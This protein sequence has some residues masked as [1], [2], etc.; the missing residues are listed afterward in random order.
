VIRCWYRQSSGTEYELRPQDISGF[1]LNIPYVNNRG[2][3]HNLG[4]QYALQYTVTNAQQRETIEQIR[5]RAPQVNQTYGRMVNGEDYNVYPLNTNRAIKLKAVNR[6]YAGHNRYFDLNDP[7][8]KYQNTNVFAEDGIIYREFEYKYD[9]EPLPTSKDASEIIYDRI[10]P[11][12]QAPELANFYYWYVT[13]NDTIH[14]HVGDFRVENTTTLI[15]RRAEKA[16]YSSTGVFGTSLTNPVPVGGTTIG[17]SHY[18]TAGAI[19]KFRDA[20]WA[21]IK[22]VRGDGTYV[23]N[24]ASASGPGAIELDQAVATGDPLEFIIPT[25]RRVFIDAELEKIR[26]QIRETNTFGLRY[27]V[28]DRAWKVITAPNLNEEAVYS[29]EFAGDTSLTNKDASWMIKAV[30]TP[31]SWKFTCR[32]LQ[33]VFESDKDVRFFYFNGYKTV[34]IATAKAVKD[35]IRILK[36]NN[37]PLNTE[38]F[39]E[40]IKFELYDSFMYEDGHIEPR[41]VKIKPVDSDDDGNPDNPLAFDAVVYP[42][43]FEQPWDTTQIPSPNEDSV[44]DYLVFW[45]LYT[46]NDG[47]QYYKPMVKGSDIRRYED[48]AN[49]DWQYGDVGYSPITKKFYE[50]LVEGQKPT[51][52]A[53]AGKYVAH[54]GRGLVSEAEDAGL[55]FQ[56]RHFAAFD[57]RID[58]APS[59]I[60]DMFVLTQE[61]YNRVTTWINSNRRAAE[62]PKAPTSDDLRQLFTDLNAVKMQGD[63]VIYHPVTFKPVFGESAREEL[64]VKFKAIKLPTAT[65]S[66]GEIKSQI[67]RSINDFFVIENWDFG[68][69]FY[70]T[71]LATYIHQNLITEIASVVPVPMNEEAKFGNLFQIRCEPDEVFISTATVADVQIVTTY[72]QSNLRIGN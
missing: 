33:Y 61:Y 24:G 28:Y 68:E 1:I 6:T 51:T 53:A 43:R 4:L 57:H 64:R 45:R 48:T 46:D 25:F 52:P 39:G 7:T 34:D 29:T 42:H 32:G 44:W 17:A 3:V 71:E 59:N 70:F 31:S 10:I 65:L 19:A 16:L 2:E 41:R 20:G 56:W 18:I 54:E 40:D 12:V 9:E 49:V 55:L 36:V 47:Y 14:P 69:S 66:D 35:Y 22:S 37:K 62:F 11:M 13:T 30:Y 50:C 23:G 38:Q 67:I 8:G 63:E 72:T 26:E 21:N 5:L 58:P 27:D 15:W 60:I